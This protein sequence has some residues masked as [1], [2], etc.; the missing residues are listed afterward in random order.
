MKF[1]FLE[2]PNQ[3]WSQKIQFKGMLWSASFFFYS[4][5]YIQSWKTVI[6]ETNLDNEF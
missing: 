3:S 5:I 4:L 6:F 2:Q 1:E